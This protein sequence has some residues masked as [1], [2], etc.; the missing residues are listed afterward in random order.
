MAE[1]DVAP[2]NTE[3][4]TGAPTGTAIP[5]LFPDVALLRLCSANVCTR[6]HE[7]IPKINLVKCGYGT[8]QGW[9]G[10]GAPVLAVKI[11]ACPICNEPVAKFRFR[12]DHTPPTP[13]LSPMCI[14]GSQTHAD[15]AVVE[16]NRDVAKIE[17]DYEAKFPA[18]PAV[19]VETKENE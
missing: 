7:W 17:A 13:F 5:T 2:T 19:P 18:L 4:T 14:P 3:S 9:N 15:I 11:E 1:I 8:P 10:C 16:I 6:G 12:T